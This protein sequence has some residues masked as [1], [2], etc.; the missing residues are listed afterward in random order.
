MTRRARIARLLLLVA[1]V[2]ILV[3]TVLVRTP[4]P[5]GQAL[6]R[7]TC[8]FSGPVRVMDVGRIPPEDT[9]P[10]RV[11]EDVHARQCDELGWLRMR[12]K[13][14]TAGGRL[15]LEAA[16]YCAG[17]RARLRRGDSYA[18]TRERLFDDA[19]AMFAGTLDS[20]RV[21]AALRASCPELTASVVQ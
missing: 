14:L 16:G 12:L 7:T 19:N 3:L 10:V 4:T 1:L 2:G 11:H 17:A 18:L 15:S 5:Q 20:A 6:A 21:N 9:L 8:A 13:N